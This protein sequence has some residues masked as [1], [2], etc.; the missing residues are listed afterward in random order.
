MTKQQELRDTQRILK[1][2]GAKGRFKYDIKEVEKHVRDGYLSA[3]EIAT[4]VG[5]SKANIMHLKKQNPDWVAS[6][7]E[8]VVHRLVSE[9]IIYREGGVGATVESRTDIAL[10]H[11]R[12]LA[13]ARGIMRELMREVKVIKETGTALTAMYK[14]INIIMPII[15]AER[16]IHDMEGQAKDTSDKDTLLTIIRGRK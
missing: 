7:I 2:V 13:D 8:E 4:K 15:H 12:I 1:N 5:C 9:N 14:L 11:A 6:P 16:K 10:D 3:S